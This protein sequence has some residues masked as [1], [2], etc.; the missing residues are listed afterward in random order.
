[1]VRRPNRYENHVVDIF[2]EVEE[3][4]RE[5]R[6]QQLL[7]KYGGML[8]GACLL[9]VGATAGWKAWEW[10]QA[11]QDQDTAGLYMAAAAKT[12]LAGV[13]GP[14]RPEAIAAFDAIAGSAPTGYRVL[15]QLRSAALRADSGDLPGA[16]AQWDQI[17]ADGSADPLLRDLA[18]LTWCLH[19][20]D[21]GD[22][23]M[24]E[25]RL[26]PLIAPGNAWRSLALEQLALLKLR[27]GQAQ[28]ARSQLTKLADD[29]TAPSGVRGRASALLSRVGE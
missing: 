24:L 10:R 23:S 13:A 29:T 7:K 22:M 21:Q 6:M 17:A 1:M 27:Q 9:L 18:N 20:A 8:I 28:E 15:A 16:S 19:H 5:E 26:K 11:K 4:L 2:D 3:D 14:N 25:N 12:E